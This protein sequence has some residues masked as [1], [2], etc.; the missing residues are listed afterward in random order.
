MLYVGV[1]CATM[2]KCCCSDVTPTAESLLDTQYQARAI[3]L[4]IKHC[5]VRMLLPSGVFYCTIC[6]AIFHV[7]FMLVQDV[8]GNENDLGGW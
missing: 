1:L 4:M 3:E 2:C 8:F 7:F 5:E 6:C